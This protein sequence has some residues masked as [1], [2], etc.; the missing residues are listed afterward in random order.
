MTPAA[1]TAVVWECQVGVEAKGGGKFHL[2]YL[3]DEANV[4]CANTHF[5]LSSGILTVVVMQQARLF[6]L[7]P[8]SNNSNPYLIENLI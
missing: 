1:T 3:G 4:H 5:W 7:G 2:K 8:L 6:R